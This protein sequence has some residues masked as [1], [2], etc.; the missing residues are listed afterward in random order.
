L[1]WPN[2]AGASRC[3]LEAIS[4]VEGKFHCER[5][6]RMRWTDAGWSG[7]MHHFRIHDG[8]IIALGLLSCTSTGCA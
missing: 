8:R 5:V 3:F 1:H 6:K 2:S 4:L 7:S